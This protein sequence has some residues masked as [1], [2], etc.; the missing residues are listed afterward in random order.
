[1][2][3]QP[4]NPKFTADE[5]GNF[6]AEVTISSS[7]DAL[8]QLDYSFGEEGVLVTVEKDGDHISLDMAPSD[9]S[10]LRETLDRCEERLAA[11]QE[12]IRANADWQADS[13]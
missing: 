9:I 10:A 2:T 3:D 8:V 13:P 5:P 12:A 7:K 4:L 1:M 11:E 6:F